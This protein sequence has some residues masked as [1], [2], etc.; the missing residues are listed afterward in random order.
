VNLNSAARFDSA[1]RQ[2]KGGAMKALEITLTV[3]A[4]S[5]AGIIL[6]ALWPWLLKLLA[7]AQQLHNL[8]L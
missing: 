3:L 5:L 7:A 8:G 6:W 1:P 2:Q 4:W